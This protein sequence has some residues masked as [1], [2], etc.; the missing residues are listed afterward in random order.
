[1]L[2]VLDEFSDGV[3]RK[4]PKSVANVATWSRSQRTSV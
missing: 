4:F 2:G 3:A 1:M